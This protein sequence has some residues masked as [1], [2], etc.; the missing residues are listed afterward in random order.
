[1]TPR[2][3]FHRIRPGK[4]TVILG[5]LILV[6][7]VFRLWTVMM[8]HTGIDERD[9]WYSAKAISQGAAVEYPYINHRTIRWGVIVPVA[10]QQLLTGI[11]PNS[12]YVMPILNALVQTALLYLLGRTLFSRRTAVLATLALI[13]FPYQIRAASQ[14]RPE[15]FSI[16]YILAMV[17]FFTGYLFKGPV[18][19][20]LKNLAL[21]SVMLFLAY[22]AKIT[23]LFFLPGMFFLILLYSS[24]KR[25]RDC[26]LFGGIP[27][28]GFILETVLYGIFAGFPLGHLQIIAANHLKG[29]ESLSSFMEIFDRYRSPYLQA[30]WQLP[31]ALFAF[32][33]GYS[34]LKKNR[35]TRLMALIVPA[36][37]FFFF[38]T[39]TISSI[40]PLRMAEPFINRYFSAVLPFVF[41][42]IGHYADLALNRLRFPR[43][44]AQQAAGILFAGTI[45]FA[46]VFS[47]PQVPS[48][49]K[50]YILPPFSPEHPFAL[51]CQ[52]REIINTAWESG[53]PI[54]S[55]PGNAGN[56][57]LGTA[58]WYYIDTDNYR[59][60]R[61][62][63]AQM[64][65]AGDQSFPVNSLDGRRPNPDGFVLAAIRKPFRVQHIPSAAFNQ[66]EGD[67]FPD[68]H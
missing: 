38:I 25:I 45:A 39:V 9:Y 32:L 62:P 12:Y 65:T 48:V 35:E 30:Y 20:R 53:S 54:V 23:N 18:S 36:L 59:N 57:A 24:G 16:T 40:H 8:I 21:A 17:Y 10:V 3:A 47:L 64:I 52:Y 44:R 5:S 63:K 42:L 56:N 14:I 33:A 43:I 55:K 41:L 34:I 31:F 27:L 51:N 2:L 11:H 50:T 58:S 49:L 46:S 7:L 15:I 28:A 67:S 60:A 37:S 61:A 68:Q 66:L 22:Q 26:L 4:D 6:C 19:K 1:M 13:F 29:M